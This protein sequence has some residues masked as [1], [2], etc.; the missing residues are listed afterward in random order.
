LCYILTRTFILAEVITLIK[1]D[2]V[3]CVLTGDSVY[4]GLYISP[5]ED[6]KGFNRSQNQLNSWVNDDW[7]ISNNISQYR[8]ITDI[9]WESLEISKPSF[10]LLQNNSAVTF[11]VCHK[12]DLV[13]KLFDVDKK[14]ERSFKV[15]S[16]IHQPF[17]NW[18]HYALYI[19]PKTQ[20]QSVTVS[21]TLG[22]LLKKEQIEKLK[23]GNEETKK[24]YQLWNLY[25]NKLIETVHFTPKWL[26]IGERET[27]KIVKHKYRYSNRTSE[28]YSYLVIPRLSKHLCISMFISVDMDCYLN[29]TLKSGNETVNQTVTGFNEE[30][31]LKEW[32]KIEIENNFAENAKLMFFRGHSS[33][34]KEGYWAVDNIAF[35]RSSVETNN[36]NLPPSISY[37][38]MCKVLNTNLTNTK[39]CEKRGYI[40][41]NCNIS[42]SQVLGKSYPNCETYKICSENSNCSCAWGYGGEFCNK[43]CDSGHWGMN[44]SL[45]CGPNCETCDNMIGCTKCKKEFFS[46]LPR[47]S[48]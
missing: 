22:E 2:N 21:G 5:L 26:S 25:D 31:S 39:I 36:I 20:M 41:N 12:N 38:S 15:K 44:C 4:S 33:G 9:R 24:D 14:D 37:K 17:C 1:N 35:C 16:R 23:K 45:N 43:T 27:V 19:M 8:P 30:N 34:R 46:G 7:L 28:N 13:F 40:G 29:V 42:C 11:S 3:T 18:S 32:K 47:L 48:M 10:I 6:Q